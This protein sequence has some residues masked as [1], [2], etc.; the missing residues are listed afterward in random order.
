MIGELSREWDQVEDATTAYALCWRLVASTNGPIDRKTTA[1]A[2]RLAKAYSPQMYALVLDTA[3]TR[4]AEW[5][6]RQVLNQRSWQ[7]KVSRRPARGR[8]HDSWQIREKYVRYS[9]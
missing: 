9:S 3:L 2:L 1:F 7:S 5:R 6:T 4:R 8:H